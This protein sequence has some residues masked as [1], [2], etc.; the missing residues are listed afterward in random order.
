[1]LDVDCFCF[2]KAAL[3]FFACFV[4]VVLL[5]LLFVEA[6]FAFLACFF[7]HYYLSFIFFLQIVAALSR[8]HVQQACFGYV[9]VL[10]RQ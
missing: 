1:M 9:L 5:A 4:K 2:V 6:V 10:S 3:D 7:V 8:G